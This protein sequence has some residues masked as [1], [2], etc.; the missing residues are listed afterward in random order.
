[1]RPLADRP[2]HRRPGAGGSHVPRRAVGR[3][4]PAQR[5]VAPDA[6]QHST[7][8]HPVLRHALR[9]RR[10]DVP[11]QR[12]GARRCWSGTPTS[13]TCAGGSG[14]APRSTARRPRRG[15]RLRGG[16]DRGRRAGARCAPPASWWRAVATTVRRCRRCPG[17][18]RSRASAGCG[19]RSPTPVPRSTVGGGCWSCGGS[20]SAL[21]VASDLAL[22][23]AAEVHLAQRRQRY[24]MPKMVAGTPIESYVF[25][26]EGAP[27]ARVVVVGRAARRHRGAH[28]L[29]GRR[30][31]PVRRAG[32]APRHRAGGGHRQ[33]ALPQPRGGGPHQ[34]APVG[35]RGRR[36]HGRVHRRDAGRGRHHRPR[37]GFRPAPAVPRP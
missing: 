8:P 29:P 3:D 4:Q 24:V 13:S 10:A 2:G 30:P 17:S 32:A 33:P 26:R 37:N 35:P 7:F 21:E 27:R 22:G 16:V 6:H 14:S 20:I 18:T 19:T 28:P 34:R 12:R 1:M 15:R 23:G 5:R 11:A 25:T 36:R 31:H 9:R